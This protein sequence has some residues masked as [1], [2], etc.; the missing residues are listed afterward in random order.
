[1]EKVDVLDRRD[2]NED[3]I[4]SI[5]G[6]IN[7][8]KQWIPVRYEMT[9]TPR[10]RE[11]PEIPYDALREAVIN[12]VT[13]R[14]YFERGANVMVEMFDDRIEITNPGGLVKGLRPEDFGKRSVLRN[15][16]IANLLREVRYI[17]R[18][19][20]GTQRMIQD[21]L[22]YDL[23]EPDFVQV[24]GGFE[25]V[26]RKAE[27]ILKTLNERQKQAWKYLRENETITN[28]IYVDLCKCPP[29]TALSDLQDLVKRGILKRE[30]VGKAT[31]HRRIR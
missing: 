3:L 20:T 16:N 28:S 6:A 21:T 4:S 12:A 13:H 29:R 18:W 2:F 31:I 17:E 1:M 10:R 9:G 24:R 14:N 11:V 23:P 27:A 15:P 22:A 8:L 30:G 19:G 25:V 26:F 5:D 7:F